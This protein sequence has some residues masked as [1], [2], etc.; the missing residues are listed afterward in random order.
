MDVKAGDHLVVRGHTVARPDRTAEVLKVLGTNGGPP[1]QVRWME[2]GHEGLF[3]PGS[4]TLVEHVP[5]ASKKS[6]K[7]P[8]RAG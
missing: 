4:D 1:Y 3:F 5:K 6:Q 7:Q 8:R 2:D